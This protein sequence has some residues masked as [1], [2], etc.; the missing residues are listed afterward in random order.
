MRKRKKWRL[1]FALLVVAYVGSYVWISRHGYA[2][3]DRYNIQGF[4]YIFPNMSE[5]WWQK[6]VVCISIFSPL[7][8]VDQFIGYG[9]PP[10]SPPLIGF[11]K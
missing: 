10:A 6:N 8:H 7:N 5:T 2:E 4:Y 11:S 1:A 9:R 3:A